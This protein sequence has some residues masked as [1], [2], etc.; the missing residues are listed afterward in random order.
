MET[1]KNPKA[2]LEKQRTGFVLLGFIFALSII[3]LAFEW[4]TR[5]SQVEK[6]EKIVMNTDEE[7]I[8]VTNEPEPPTPTKP[9]E[10]ITDLFE[11]KENDVQIDDQNLDLDF[12]TD[13]DD[14]IDIPDFETNQPD[15]DEPVFMVVE[16][17]PSFPGGEEAFR[18]FLRDNI[19]YPDAARDHGI[20]GTVY[21]QFVVNTDGSVSGVK[22]VRGVDP[23]LDEEAMRVVKMVPRWNPGKQRGK[24]VKALFTVPIK[25]QLAN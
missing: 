10:Q 12:E 25:F 24:P 11:I 9:P 18:E 14:I 23:L 3:F 6:L 5:P 22:A 8:A 7:I 15:M 1:K 20:E 19:E 2:D 13:E 4:T 16:E 21:V 17:Q